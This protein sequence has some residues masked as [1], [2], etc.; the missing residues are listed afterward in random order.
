MV[1]DT[2]TGEVVARFECFVRPSFN[3]RVS[4][5]CFE[6]T[7]ITQEQVD[8]GVSLAEAMRRHQ[9]FVA[10][11]MADGLLLT[12][13]DWDLKTMLPADAK[14]NDI[15]VP[16]FYKSWINIRVQFHAL[17]QADEVR[18]RPPGMAGMLKRLEIPLLGTHHRGIDDCVNTAALAARMIRDGWGSCGGGGGSDGSSVDDVY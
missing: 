11:Y 10:P 4:A 18:S 3:P 14:L 6:L 9:D 1:L 5:F 7:T 13:G 16:S 17:Y 2:T 8:G 15:E 12:C